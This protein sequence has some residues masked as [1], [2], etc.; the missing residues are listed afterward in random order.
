MGITHRPGRGHG[1][2]GRAGPESQ[3][4]QTV[5]ATKTVAP[6]SITNTRV[7][8]GCRPP[9]ASRT[10]RAACRIIWPV[11]TCGVAARPRALP[12]RLGPFCGCRPRLVVFMSLS[13]T[14]GRTTSARPRK[15]TVVTV[16]SAAAGGQPF[17]AVRKERRTDDRQGAGSGCQ[18]RRGAAKRRVFSGTS[19]PS[20]GDIVSPPCSPP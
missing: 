3:N 13:R 2:G 1:R 19:E 10:C 7:L 18:A 4:A 11:A 6:V 9:S 16:V 5:R 8:A 12:Q 17:G 20:A 15:E 14:V